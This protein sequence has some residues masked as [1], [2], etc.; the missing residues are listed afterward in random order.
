[1]IEAVQGLRTPQAPAVRSEGNRVL[2]T[3]G[4]GAQILQDLGIRRMRVLS[5]PWQLR[6]LSA[7]DLEITEYGHRRITTM[8]IRTA[9]ATPRRATCTSPS[10]LR[11]S[12]SW[13]QPSAALSTR[14]GVTAR[15]DAVELIRVPGALSCRRH[16]QVAGTA[17]LDAIIALGAVIRGETARFDYVAGECSRGYALAIESVRSAFGTRPSR[18]SRRWRGAD[19][20]NKGAEAAVTAIE[21]ANLLRRLDT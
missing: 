20:D 2:R 9:K 15:A 21:M 19:G 7:F 17:A 3:Y 13:S 1:L 14:S 5:A 6:G 16:P 18:S 10:S 12:G 4:I 11:A 8:D